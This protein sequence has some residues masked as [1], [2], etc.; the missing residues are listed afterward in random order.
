VF[1]WFLIVPQFLPGNGE[2]Y[3]YI[4]SSVWH[5]FITVSNYGLRMAGGIGDLMEILP[6]GGSGYTKLTIYEI[7]FY[8]VITILLL[9][10]FLG[11]ILDT[12]ANVRDEK[13]HREHDMKYK[14][15]ICNVDK[16]IFEKEGVSF[17]K[18][19]KV[20]H[21]VW[22]Y[23]FFMIHLKLKD[24]FD[25][26]GTESLVANKLKKEDFS[27]F[28]ISQAMSLENM[29][30]KMKSLENQNKILQD[31]LDDRMEAMEK[32]MYTVITNLLNKKEEVK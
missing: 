15:F 5:C 16:T 17:K 13:Q 26:T 7:I 22:N 12:F 14:C 10:L 3:E 30:A 21:N 20:E 2:N 11:I 27:W 9:Y 6:F 4:C 31:F 19:T 28:P 25:Y 23:I 24:P 18:H 29:D 32:K 1:A 8:L